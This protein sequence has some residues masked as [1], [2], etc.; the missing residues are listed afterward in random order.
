MF[1]IKSERIFQLATVTVINSLCNGV[2]VSLATLDIHAVNRHGG[3]VLSHLN[4]DDLVQS[5]HRAI[6]QMRNDC[7]DGLEHVVVSILRY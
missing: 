6:T 2:A 7:I 4:V 3:L 1:A 5:I